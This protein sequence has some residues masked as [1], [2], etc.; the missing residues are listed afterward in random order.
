ML[1][2]ALVALALFLSGAAALANQVVWQRAL[3]IFV[4][5]SE[6]LASMVVVLVFMGGGWPRTAPRGSPTRSGP[7]RCSR[8]PSP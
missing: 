5:G 1:A 6:E 3:K 4:G 2:R 7:S 8:E